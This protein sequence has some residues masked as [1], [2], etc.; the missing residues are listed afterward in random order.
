MDGADDDDDDDDAHDENGGGLLRVPMAASESGVDG[1]DTMM[2]HTELL[3][4]PVEI[5]SGAT[6]MSAR[7]R[8]SVAGP[9]C[10]SSTCGICAL[11]RLFGW[12]AAAAAASTASAE[13]V[14]AL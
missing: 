12:A 6:C 11:V 8:S 14:S 13:S 10:T 9:L 1:V 3:R 5:D 2:L 7:R 4:L